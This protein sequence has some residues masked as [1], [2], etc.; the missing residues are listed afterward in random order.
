MDL[1]LGFLVCSTDLY[2]CLCASTVLPWWL[3]LY[4]IVW[5][6][7]SWFLL[8]CSFSRLLCLFKVFFFFL[9]CMCVCVCVSIQLVKLFVLVLWKIPLV[10][11]KILNLDITFKSFSNYDF[12]LLLDSHSLL[13]V[14]LNVLSITQSVNQ[15]SSC[16]HWMFIP[17]SFLG[18]VFSFLQNPF[19]CKL[20]ILSVIQR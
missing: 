3:Q 11:I 14:H 16:S 5:S 18:Q 20:Q 12:S 8:F 15:L 6:Q 1:S 2:L 17:N 4:G 13:F 19:S 10:E 9:L 7:E